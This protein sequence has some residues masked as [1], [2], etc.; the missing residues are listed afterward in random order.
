MSGDKPL[1]IGRSKIQGRIVNEAVGTFTRVELTGEQISDRGFTE[2]DVF[3]TL[4][5]PDQEG[6]PTQPGRKA[7]RDAIKPLVW[8]AMSSTKNSRIDSGLSQ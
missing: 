3:L 4:R 7:R 8:P 1:E 5:G 6:L 2:A